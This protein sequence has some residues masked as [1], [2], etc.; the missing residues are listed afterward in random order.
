[1]IDLSSIHQE[2][3]GSPDE[4]EEGTA[5]WYEQIPR[6]VVKGA[7]LG[8]A[9]SWLTPFAGAGAGGIPEFLG[10]VGGAALPWMAAAK[11]AAIPIAAAGRILPRVLNPSLIARTGS[12]AKASSEAL[13]SLTPKGI[14]DALRLAP[15]QE[16]LSTTGRL[17]AYGTAGALTSFIPAEFEEPS[18]SARSVIGRT[19]LGGILGLAGEGI[20]QRFARGKSAAERVLGKTAQDLSDP[21]T[22]HALFSTAIADLERQIGE[23]T[24]RIKTAT[25]V[26][27]IKL[28]HKQI[29]DKQTIIGKLKLQQ[30]Q[31]PASLAPT[32]PQL[33][34]EFPGPLSEASS[35]GELFSGVPAPKPGVAGGVRHVPVPPIPR[36][37]VGTQL[38]FEFPVPSAQRDLFFGGAVPQPKPGSVGGVLREP[39]PLP[40]SPIPLRGGAEAQQF[41]RTATPEQVNQ[42]LKE[43]GVASIGNT[44]ARNRQLL[45]DEVERRAQRALSAPTETLRDPKT[46]QFSLTQV[47]AREAPVHLE[48]NPR[49]GQFD[50]RQEHLI[51]PGLTP[52][53]GEIAIIEKNW[54]AKAQKAWG[55]RPINPTG[56]KLADAL[57]V[58][59]NNQS[60]LLPADVDLATRIAHDV[61]VNPINGICEAGSWLSDGAFKDMFGQA[62]AGV[63]GVGRRASRGFC[64]TFLPAT[65]VLSGT[66]L[67][68]L[69]NWLDRIVGLSD[70][71][72]AGQWRDIPEIA[73]WSPELKK[74]IGRLF[75]EH[76]KGTPEEFA[77][78][79]A[80]EA[81]AALDGLP[82]L[83][84]KLEQIRLQYVV[85]GILDPDQRI[86]NYFPVVR[87]NLGTKLSGTLMIEAGEQ[88]YIPVPIDNI[89]STRLPAFA[90]RRVLR[91]PGTLPQNI[92]FDDTLNMYFTQFGRHTAVR[93]VMSDVNSLLA[94]APDEYKLYAGNLVNYALGNPS[95]MTPSGAWTRIL[96]N[97]QFARTIGLNVLSP[98][99]NTMQKI[100]TWSMVHSSSFLKAFDDLKDPS[101]LAMLK[102]T[103]LEDLLE[104]TQTGLGLGKFDI[105]PSLRGGL[106]GYASRISQFSGKLFSYSEKHNRL[107]AFFAGVREAER[108]GI[109]QEQWFEFGNDIVNR[110]QFIQSA[111]NAPQLFRLTPSAPLGRLGPIVGQFQTFRLNQMHMMAKQALDASKGVLSGDFEKALP[112]VKFWTASALLGGG[113][114]LSIGTLTEDR[115]T[116]DL[117]GKAVHVPG[118]TELLGVSLASQM[119]MGAVN[120]DDVRSWLFFLPGPT[121]GYMQGLV[122]AVT[123]TN[124]GQGLDM[125][126][127]GKDLGFQERVQMV[128]QSIPFMPWL[129][130]NR[131][132]NALR[133]VQ[134]NGE[135]RRAMDLSEVVGTKPA[136]GDLL[137]EKAASAEQ[138]LM[139][140]VGLPNVQRMQELKRGERIRDV[141]SDVNKARR[142]A[143]DLISRGKSDEAMTLLKEIQRKYI[144]EKIGPVTVS[145]QSVRAAYLRK[146]VPPGARQ[147]L[148]GYLQGS[149]FAETET[150]SIFDLIESE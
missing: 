91:A 142:E 100:N 42:Y 129:Q 5:P 147:R 10:E 101:R 123:G 6:G 136:T 51:P 135:Y 2:L 15:L 115:F 117:F 27:E 52:F 35:Q 48:F 102:G 145:P 111:A 22:R 9:P 59:N 99:V 103:H 13:S 85:D 68:K 95:A 78:A 61:P 12:A 126:R 55:I 84:N 24:E 63:A 134:T 132:L 44:L 7:S 67:E 65:A 71:V 60:H 62:E 33:S 14:R 122:G 79:V 69:P 96:K 113:G 114:A 73:R 81:P 32:S 148:P 72:R 29:R 110:S 31:L 77:E 109:P 82:V 19:A 36:E 127:L 37:L 46:G 108:L 39:V 146:I 70:A 128:G 8:L 140:A 98:I 3:Y 47:T 118:L 124:V 130:V 104:H 34:M 58:M 1:M 105:D 75:F 80:R 57:Y 116:H 119:G 133:L 4:P 112:F 43:F 54:Q 144:D 49:T 107:H 53:K 87:E 56:D 41:V 66:V 74:T 93:S 16:A 23:M 139:A 76:Q 106:E 38:P 17:G 121:M 64:S 18:V 90:R 120:I 149:E 28:L 50:R 26:D 141:E 131:V 94:K 89:L 45:L 138:V 88:G 40:S 30:E 137:A 21:S 92:S 125:S 83:Q 86:L 25:S 143:A 20:A 150:P 11:A 97:M